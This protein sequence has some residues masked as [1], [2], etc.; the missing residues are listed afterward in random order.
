MLNLKFNSI[1]INIYIYRN[2][3]LPICL[4]TKH[5]DLIGKK[6]II[7]GWGKTEVNM[8]HTGTNILQAAAVP[9]IGKKK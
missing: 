9:I 2:H 7:A 5:I 4:P 1:Y 6:G 8:A 3:I